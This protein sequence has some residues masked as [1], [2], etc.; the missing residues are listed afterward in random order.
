A[1]DVL[2][3]DQSDQLFLNRGDGTFDEA[4]ARGGSV[5]SDPDVA[6]GLAR[7]DVDNDG[8]PDLLMTN[9][10]GPAQLLANQTKDAPWFGLDL[11]LA[12]GG[13]AVGGHI[14]AQQV[15]R[16][17]HR[18]AHTDGSFAAAHDPRLV[19]GLGD[20]GLLV[21]DVTW[22]DGSKLRLAAPPTDRYLVLRQP[23]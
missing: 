13:A 19:V 16:S 1:G 17:V 12:N 23:E 14:N 10:A 3:L 22:P 5:F 7:G 6:R 9:N 2:P 11:R 18:R 15:G 4:T 21:V 8:A 20:K